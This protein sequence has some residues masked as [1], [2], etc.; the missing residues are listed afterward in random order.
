[1]IYD[2]DFEKGRQL[3]IYQKNRGRSHQRSLRGPQ[4]RRNRPLRHKD[5]Q[6]QV[7]EQIAER[8]DHQ[9]SHNHKEYTASSHRKAT[10]NPR[11]HEP[12]LPHIL[13]LLKR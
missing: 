1:M 5:D 4:R 3:Q 10:L 9:V 12:L 8:H 11:N 7:H 2:L 13:I 6:N